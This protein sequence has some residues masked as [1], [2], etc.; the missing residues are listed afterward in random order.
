[1]RSARLAALAALVCFVPVSVWL[2]GQAGVTVTAD[3]GAMPGVLRAALQGLWMAQLPAAV[4]LASALAE[5]RVP[6][7][8]AAILVFWLVPLPLLVILWAGGV[9][10]GTLFSGV[11]FGPL[12]SACLA[13]LHCGVAWLGPT[14]RDEAK[15]LLTL[16]GAFVLWVFR[17]DWLALAGS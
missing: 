7:Q 4:L 10:A 14:F 8:A 15:G 9:S 12:F 11:G 3:P 16:A 13:V 6:E 1:M 17:E 2:I 5:S